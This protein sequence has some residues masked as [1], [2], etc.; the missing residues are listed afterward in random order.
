MLKFKNE[1]YLAIVFQ[2][3]A[4]FHIWNGQPFLRS[5]L[6]RIAQTDPASSDRVCVRLLRSNGRDCSFLGLMQSKSHFYYI[7]KQTS[8]PTR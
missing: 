4:H 5:Q 1:P 3:S 6:N 8:L 2:F 7:D